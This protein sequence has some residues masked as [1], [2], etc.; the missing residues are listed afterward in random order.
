M[1]TATVNDIE[2]SYELHGEGTPALYI[3][4]GFGGETTTLAPGKRAIVDALP[5]ADVQ[6]ITYDRRCA[7]ASEYTID[8]A[9]T[10]RD[11]A[12]DARAL[13]AHLGH[14]RAIIIGSSMGGMVA[15]QYACDYPETVRALALLNTGVDLMADMPMAPRLVETVHRVE[16]EGAEV[17]F[18][19]L[20]D[21]LRNPSPLPLDASTPLAMNQAA[22]RKRFLEVIADVSG[23]RLFRW[24]RG[25]VRNQA[26]FIEYSFAPHL[27]EIDAID[28]PKA[29]VHGD[30][31]HIVPFAFGQQLHE[32]IPSAG[33][34]VIEGADHGI[35][36]YPE[37]QDVIRDWLARVA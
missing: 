12:A 6:L 4:G 36:N 16:S 13:L 17:V 23:E 24:W 2:I 8:E 3:H 5:Q 7:G 27:G 25:A 11:I 20:S 9:F 15:Q 30:D 29:I 10:L 33:F 37:A 32:G 28:A 22:A 31:D 34:H 14:D 21:Q 26:A 1:P 19:G 18:D 35:D